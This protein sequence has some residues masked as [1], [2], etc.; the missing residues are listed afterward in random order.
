MWNGGMQVRHSASHPQ[1]QRRKPR[2]LDDQVLPNNEDSVLKRHG[3]N[4][5]DHQAVQRTARGLRGGL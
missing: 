2:L 4:R 1:E 5:L 3:E